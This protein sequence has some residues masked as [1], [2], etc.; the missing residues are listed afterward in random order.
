MELSCHPSC[1]RGCRVRV[2]QLGQSLR[3][4]L[5]GQQA[6]WP[7]ENSEADLQGSAVGRGAGG[8]CASR[9]PTA[10]APASMCAVTG[11]PALP[12]IPG[13]SFP[14]C[15]LKGGTLRC[16]GGPSRC[17]HPQCSA[18]PCLPLRGER[19]VRTPGARAVP[20]QLWWLPR[21]GTWFAAHACLSVQSLWLRTY[22]HWISSE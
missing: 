2:L 10:S 21:G 18:E 11:W 3:V 15:T 9:A 20:A 12:G 13:L 22:H 16:L 5:A 7:R 19:N 4:C 1:G 14:T 8:R 6:L 17:G